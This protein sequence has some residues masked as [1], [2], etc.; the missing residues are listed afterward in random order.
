M[1]EAAKYIEFVCVTG[2]SA[3]FMFYKPVVLQTTHVKPSSTEPEI[4]DYPSLRIWGI[5]NIMV[6]IWVPIIIRGLI[7]GPA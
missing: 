5:V 1:S 2:R 7:R 4:S 6:P 3:M